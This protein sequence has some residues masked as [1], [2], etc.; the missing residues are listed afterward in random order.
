[1]LSMNMSSVLGFVDDTKF[2]EGVDVASV[3]AA[4]LNEEPFEAVGTFE[5][6]MFDPV[7][8]EDAGGP[9]PAC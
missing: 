3:F 1:M 8:I 6:V 4:G 2:A 7:G 9:V 5:V